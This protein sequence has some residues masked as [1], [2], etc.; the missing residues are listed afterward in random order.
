MTDHTIAHRYEVE[1]RQLVLG[2]LRTYDPKMLERQYRA[3]VLTQGRKVEGLPEKRVDC[4]PLCDCMKSGDA[5]I[6]NTHDEWCDD[7]YCLCHVEAAP[8][9]AH[10]IPEV[11]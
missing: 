5:E 4:C 7:Y 11:S 1:A 6:E 10:L 8:S 3:G 9:R 2:A